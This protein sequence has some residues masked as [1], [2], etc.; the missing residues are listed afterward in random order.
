MKGGQRQSSYLMEENCCGLKTLHGFRWETAPVIITHN[1][2]GLTIRP[3]LLVMGYSQE[4]HGTLQ[5]VITTAWQLADRLLIGF[6]CESTA[7]LKSL[8]TLNGALRGSGDV[9]EWVDAAPLFWKG[10]EMALGLGEATD[11]LRHTRCCPALKGIRRVF[12]RL[13]IWTHSKSTYASAKVLNC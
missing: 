13:S 12:R 3:A 1:V 4:K 8:F 2:N 7:A 9:F 5:W 6:Y 10:L 11:G